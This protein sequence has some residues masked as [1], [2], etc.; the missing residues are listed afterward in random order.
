MCSQTHEPCHQT[1][2]LNH[3][4][5]D[6]KT[7]VLTYEVC[8]FPLQSLVNLSLGGYKK[9]FNPKIENKEVIVFQRILKNYRFF[10]TF[11]F[12]YCKENSVILCQ[13]QVDQ[14]SRLAQV[15]NCLLLMLAMEQRSK[16][17]LKL[18]QKKSW[19]NC[20]NSLPWSPNQLK[21]R[22][23][24]LLFLIDDGKVK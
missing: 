4:S 1:Q 20:N 19:K 2:G 8:R 23:N 24:V 16:Y 3:R 9:I 6:P 18:R 11:I 22:I 10:W 5:L 17:N 12:N 7:V 13:Q 21:Q 14:F 15:R